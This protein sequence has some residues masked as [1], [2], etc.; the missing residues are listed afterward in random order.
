MF[1]KVLGLV[2]LT[3]ITIFFSFSENEV[4]KDA[5]NNKSQIKNCNKLNYE[6]V[7]YIDNLDYADLNFGVIFNDERKWKK[8]LL[9]DNVN[10]YKNQKISE[11]NLRIYSISKRHSGLIELRTEKLKCYFKA[12]LRPHGNFEDHRGGLDIPSLNIN[13]KEGN[14]KGITKFLFLRPETRNYDNEIFNSVLFR[15]FGFLSP[16]TFN[17]NLIYNNKTYRIIFQEKIVKEF[18]ENSDLRE[19]FITE[20]DERFLWFDSVDS[21]NYS[22]F[23]VSNHKLI[24]K[25]SK[26]YKIA[27]YAIS[28]LNDLERLNVRLDQDYT[29]YSTLSKILNENYFVRL[30]VYEALIYGLN[31]EHGLQ[32]DE[33]KFYFDPFKRNFIPIYYDG[34]GNLLN[35][36]GKLSEKKIN[37][38]PKFLP[39]AK[40]GSNSALLILQNIDLKIL[41]KDLAKMKLII[42]END[43]EKILKK[44]EFNLKFLRSLDDERLYKISINKKNEIIN[45]NSRFNEKLKRKFVYYKNDFNGYLQCEFYKKNC[46]NFNLSEKDKSEL[47]RQNLSHDDVNFIFTGSTIDNLKS[48]N[49]YYQ[50]LN[51]INDRKFTVLNLENNIK[52]FHNNKVNIEIDKNKK[53]IHIENFDDEKVVFFDS[54]LKNWEINFSRNLLYN[55]NKLINNTDRTDEFG[56]TG[57]LSFIDTKVYNLNLKIENMNCED[58][59]N[60]IRARGIIKKIE[61]N[62]AKFDG[63]DADFSELIFEDINV[64]SSL[65]DCLDFSYGKYE[66]KKAKLT[67]CG[68]KSISAGERSLLNINNLEIFNSQIG[69]ASKDSSKV[70]LD[71]AQIKQVN[72]CLSAYKKKQEF[73][74]GYIL[75]NNI[76]CEEYNQFKEFDSYSKIEIRSKNL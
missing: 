42:S 39:S 20:L 71:N 32:K 36:K 43:L 62:N 21:I 47:L 5:K 22:K 75:S 56:L 44:I 16:V 57:C 63:I 55:K 26:N 58:S 18:L 13:L 35:E 15:K 45:Q 60:F 19:S 10:S 67:V 1:S 69:V 73:W 76:N 25:S 61:I 11:E 48:K 6:E 74:G 33:R 38:I 29:D 14:I 53:K 23:G 40:S 54:D 41:K 27:E 24:F 51:E 64:S 34:M 72:N 2:I 59:V 70:V 7:N 9:S 8:S 65:N 28:L 68:D 50:Y 37:E 49:F 31:A 12:K 52:I 30:N 66:I 4:F 17:S 46:K 3:I